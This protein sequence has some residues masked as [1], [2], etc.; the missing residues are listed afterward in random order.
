MKIRIKE[1]TNKTKHD[2]EL[3]ID[4]TVFNIL[5][6]GE[7]SSLHFRCFDKQVADPEWMRQAND[8]FIELYYPAPN[9]ISIDIDSNNDLWIRP[10]V[11]RE[12]LEQIIKDKEKSKAE[13]E[14]SLA[15][16]K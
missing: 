10:K 8:G 3:N 14:R 11:N 13:K 12:Q 15:H 6:E 9:N 1:R 5:F 7:V 4:F 16:L 2:K